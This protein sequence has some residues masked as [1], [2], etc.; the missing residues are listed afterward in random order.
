MIL[1]ELLPEE[2]GAAFRVQSAAFE[3]KGD[4]AAQK[5]LTRPSLG[6]FEDDGHTLMAMLTPINYQANYC[7]H[8]LPTVGVAGVASLPQYRR[9]GAVRRRSRPLR[10]SSWHDCGEHR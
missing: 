4:A 2:A 1:R 7:G 10:P 5:P 8:L 9:R 3:F 6:A